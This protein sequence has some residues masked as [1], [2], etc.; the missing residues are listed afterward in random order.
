M[1]ILYVAPRYHTNQIP[2]MK[3]WL[4]NGHQIM[5][6]SQ[7]AGTSEDY[8]VIK[9]VILGYSKIFECFI[10]LYSL[11][12]CRKEKSVTK[13]FNL[14]TKVGFP[15]L[16]EAG[17][18]IRTFVPDLVIVRERAVYNIPFTLACKKNRIPC[19]LYNQSPLWD[20]P[21]NNSSFGKKLLFSLLPTFRITPV[22]GN[23]NQGNVK[24]A[25]A[26]YIPFIIEPSFS[27]EE[28]EHFRNDKIN[29]LCVGRYEERKNLFLLLDMFRNLAQKYPIRLT[30]VGEA[31]DER[32]KE[33]YKKLKQAVQ[34]YQME[35]RVILLQ[36]FHREQ[37]FAEY[38]K[39]D[40]FILP[41]T[42]ER[43][44]ISQ[45]EAMSCSLPVICS[46]TNGSS[47]YVENGK[48]GYLFQD[49]NRQDLTEKIEKIISDKSKLLKMGQKSY[50]LVVTKY[51]FATY[52]E[53]LAEIMNRMTGAQK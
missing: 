34:E 2:V 29:L 19:I 28:K 37:V 30:I 26:F 7:F 36:N 47:C 31:L 6:I 25:G 22:F 42:R 3:G 21:G 12:F 20:R 18:Y 27:S 9:P 1:R 49:N 41:S 51:Q 44:S 52:Y 43:A 14:R 23:K 32:Q 17:K 45:L 48:N 40:L 11:L 15:P 38:R 13:E 24:E 39:A 46:N 33:Y 50:E 8:S 4:C 10:C 16:W 53:K 5:F 35:D